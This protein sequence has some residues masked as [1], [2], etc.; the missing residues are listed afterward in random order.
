[1]KLLIRTSI[2]AEVSN[3]FQIAEIIRS[4]FGW[5]HIRLGLAIWKLG[6]HMPEC[7]DLGKAGY[8]IFAR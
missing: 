8:E 5:V 3:H 6:M 2:D 7:Y 4:S 1:M